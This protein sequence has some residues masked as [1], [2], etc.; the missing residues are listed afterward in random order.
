MSPPSDWQTDGRFDD[1][2]EIIDD[3]RRVLTN[4]AIWEA[5]GKMAWAKP[6]AMCRCR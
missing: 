4:A 3:L 2:A 6:G 5:P 1:L